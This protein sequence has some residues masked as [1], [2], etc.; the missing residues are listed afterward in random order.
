MMLGPETMF[1][2][3]QRFGY[4]PQ[5][6]YAPQGYGPQTIG[7]PMNA[8]QIPPVVGNSGTAP[9]SGNFGLAG[10]TGQN[11][12]NIQAQP[13]SPVHSPLPWAVLGLI[14]AL[15]ML[16]RVHYRSIV[17][18]QERGRLGPAREEAGAGA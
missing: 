5:Y 3:G 16:H 2:N 14:F 18:V 8:P 10:A 13:F 12:N 15:I 4:T 7:V 17:E 6:V 1:A 11:V 9:G